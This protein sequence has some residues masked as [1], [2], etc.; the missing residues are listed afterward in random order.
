MITILIQRKQRG[1]IIR[2]FMRKSILLF[3][4]MA[5]II[6]ATGCEKEKSE[7]QL[8]STDKAEKAALEYMNSKY[9]EEFYILKSKKDAQYGYL[10]GT[11]QDCWIHVTVGI[12]DDDPVNEYTVQLH[13]NEDGENYD[14][15]WDDYQVH[16]ITPW[17]KSEIDKIISTIEIQD[18]ITLDSIVSEIDA[19]GN[20]FT[21]DFIVQA[22]NITIKD[23]FNLYKIVYHYT[24]LLPEKAYN[25]EIVKGINKLFRG[26]FNDDAVSITIEVITDE[27][28]SL[29]ENSVDINNSVS[30]I[31]LSDI[32]YSD[33]I[34]FNE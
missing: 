20:G 31:T 33:T 12:E 8:L 9:G 11:I 3:L 16:I 4:I 25:D 15:D 6:S 26:Y 13:L 23:F 10:P 7:Y 27:F 19:Y 34:Y 30:A 28:Y 29:C 18:Y 14:I 17:V 5:L 2:K 22:E 1:L 24:V 32:I 21:N